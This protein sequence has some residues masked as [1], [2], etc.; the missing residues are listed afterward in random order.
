MS[1]LAL[2]LRQKEVFYLCLT[3]A[4]TGDAAK[5]RRWRIRWIESP[6]KVFLTGPD[7]Q[8]VAITDQEAVQVEPGVK[9]SAGTVQENWN[10]CR[11]VF[12]AP[13][14]IRIL[15]EAIYEEKLGARNRQGDRARGHAAGRSLGR[16]DAD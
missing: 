2:G 6:E 14:S 4:P 12:D 11:L 7:G 5:D 16:T 15:R 1:T 8:N 3:G 9:I 13:Q 10:G